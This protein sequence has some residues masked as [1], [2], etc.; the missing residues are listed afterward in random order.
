MWHIC[1]IIIQVALTVIGIITLIRSIAL[2]ISS[3]VKRKRATIKKIYYMLSLLMGL[4]FIVTSLL[5]AII[6]RIDYIYVFD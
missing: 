5:I 2:L 1:L 3:D 6:R 4:F